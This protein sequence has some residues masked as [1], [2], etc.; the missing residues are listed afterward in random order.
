MSGVP[1]PNCM[2]DAFPTLATLIPSPYIIYNVAGM[3]RKPK[4]RSNTSFRVVHPCISTWYL[5]VWRRKH[6][7]AFLARSVQWGHLPYG[8]APSTGWIWWLH[9]QWI[10]KPWVAGPVTY[11]RGWGFGSQS[12]A[13]LTART[14]MNQGLLSEHAFP[15]SQFYS[16][17]STVFHTWTEGLKYTVTCI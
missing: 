8:R 10:V 3:K 4:E 15:S 2:F 9:P 12:L 13:L 16:V 1:T 6:L 14:T 17:S 7:T 11:K 5:F